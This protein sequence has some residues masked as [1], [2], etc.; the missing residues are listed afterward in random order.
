MAEIRAEDKS[1][2]E[3][4]KQITAQSSA[5]ARK[6]LELAEAE[7]T[8]KG[9]RAGLGAGMLGSAGLLGLFALAC[10]T[11][12]AILALALVVPGWAAALIVAGVYGGLAGVAAQSARR[13]RLRLDAKE[14]L[15]GRGVH[16]QEPAIGGANRDDVIRPTQPRDTIP[17]REAVIEHNGLHHTPRGE[18]PIRR[19]GRLIDRERR[20]IGQPDTR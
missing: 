5:L 16:V 1:V 17:P 7:M 8:A 19:R 4:I 14:I 6:E 13:R 20:A 9:K 3:L 15:S 2:V 18:T 12:A 10:A 11:A